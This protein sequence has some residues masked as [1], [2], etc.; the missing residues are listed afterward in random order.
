MG[1]QVIGHAGRSTAS[2]N[3][4][5]ASPHLAP[6]SI[7]CSGNLDGSPQVSLHQHQQSTTTSSGD[8]PPLSQVSCPSC[9]GGHPAQ[10]MHA[11]NSRQSCHNFF[12]IIKFLHSFCPGFEELLFGFASAF[13]CMLCRTGRK[14][15][16]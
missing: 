8:I 16:I 11:A 5:L 9:P 13:S 15:N 3:F 1:E 6:K 14:G 12:F 10:P 2:A 4:P 7:L